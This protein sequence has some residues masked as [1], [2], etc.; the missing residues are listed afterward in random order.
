MQ[1]SNILENKYAKSYKEQK[2]SS[3]NLYAIDCH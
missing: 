1:D 3:E 2:R